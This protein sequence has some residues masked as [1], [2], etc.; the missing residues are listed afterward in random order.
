MW[1]SKKRFEA[2]EKEI[3]SLNRRVSEAYGALESASHLTVFV[4]DAER[5]HTATGVHSYF[6]Y[7]PQWV[8]AKIKLTDAV[9]AIAKHVGLELKYIEGKPTRAELQPIKKKTSST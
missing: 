1:I 6:Y 4:Q 5:E 3:A 2:M 9:E 8:S 7:G